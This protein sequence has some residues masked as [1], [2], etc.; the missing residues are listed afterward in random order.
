[1]L[2]EMR[3]E[4]V[5]CIDERVCVY[6]HMGVEWHTHRDICTLIVKWALIGLCLDEREV[7]IWLT[8]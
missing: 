1:M 7:M 6:A 3:V 5:F 4:K 8:A 2:S